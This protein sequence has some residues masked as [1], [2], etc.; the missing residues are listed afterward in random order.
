[1]SC[2][3][4][5]PSPLLETYYV[6]VVVV[7]VAILSFAASTDDIFEEF[8]MIL[9]VRLDKDYLP[10]ETVCCDEDGDGTI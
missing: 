5:K 3:C 10:P 8:F 4:I 6:V 1:M 7:V 2:G 9:V